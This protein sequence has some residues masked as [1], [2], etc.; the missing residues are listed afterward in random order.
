MSRFLIIYNLSI[1][2]ILYFIIESIRSVIINNIFD[3][4]R[5]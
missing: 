2:R 5:D 1:Y 4:L 3:I